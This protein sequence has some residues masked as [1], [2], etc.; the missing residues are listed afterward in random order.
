MKKFIFLT[1]LLFDVVF[2][3]SQSSEIRYQPVRKD[4]VLAY[5]NSVSNKKI[6]KFQN[7]YKK[8]IKEMVLE[9]KKYFV[10]SIEDSSYIF[11]TKISNYL[12]GILNEIYV[13]NPSLNTQDYYFFV[14]RSPWPNAGSFGNGIF[15]VNLGLLNFVNTDDELAFM[16]CHEIAHQE[17]EHSDKA[18]LKYLETLRSKAVKKQINQ[19]SRQQYG[20]RR[21]YYDLIE[22]LE[23]NFMKRS[24]SA[25]LQA[26]SLGLAL[27]K[28]TKFNK[29]A[30]LVALQGLEISDT[31]VFNEDSKIREHFNFENYP[32]KEGWLAKDQTLFDTKESVNDYAF[33]KDSLKTHPDIP[34][35][36]EKLQKMLNEPTIPTLSAQEK[37]QQIKQY[38]ALVNVQSLLDDKRLDMAMYQT[39]VLFNKKAMDQK[40]FGLLMAQMLQKVYELKN[41]HRFGKYVSQVSS[42]SDE[43][44]LDQVKQFLHNV[45]MKQLKKIGLHF[46]QKYAQVLQDDSNFAT[47]TNY[48]NKL[49]L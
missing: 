24:R 7:K 35:R 33:N 19:V 3:F 25:E 23:T 4:S 37:F 36:I 6:A 40:T 5:I 45:E 48:F 34:L 15:S 43:Q 28:K 16:I 21:A 41:N 26:D 30:S 38:G 42:F 46:C 22:S 14:D 29:A 10:K 12:K 18:M 31:I 17:L 39:M 32:F 9:R 47:I 44:Y 11:E 20:R 27:F 2:C 49:N 13:S 8:D 1:W